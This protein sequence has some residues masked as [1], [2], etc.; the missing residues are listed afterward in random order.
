MKK[1][2]VIPGSYPYSI[3]AEDTFLNPEL[4]VLKKYFEIHIIPLSAEGILQN[5]DKDFIIHDNYAKSSM[6]LSKRLVVSYFFNIIFSRQIY[7][8]LFNFP[9]ILLNVSKVKSLTAK[10]SKTFT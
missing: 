1:L 5:I 2:I 4:K 3:A 7:M 8:E 6:K 9:L 10:E